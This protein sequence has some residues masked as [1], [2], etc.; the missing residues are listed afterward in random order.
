VL[1]KKVALFETLR[2]TQ[3]DVYPLLSTLL[4][5][6]IFGDPGFIWQLG[7]HGAAGASLGE[8]GMSKHLWI[9]YWLRTIPRQRW[10]W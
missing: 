9:T 2:F 10:R 7:M 3:G 5:I 8:N 4:K 6:L 1:A